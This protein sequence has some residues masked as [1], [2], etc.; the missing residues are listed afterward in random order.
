MKH[1]ILLEYSNTEKGWLV[2]I[3]GQPDTNDE[4]DAIKFP[5]FKEAEIYINGEYGDTSLSYTILG[6]GKTDGN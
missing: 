3:D 4:G 6:G 5:T 2:I 1:E